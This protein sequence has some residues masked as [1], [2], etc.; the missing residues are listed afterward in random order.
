M[1]K[2]PGHQQHPDH[3]VAEKHLGERIRVTVANEAVAD[4]GDVI[5]VEED[6][7]PERYYFPRSDVAMERLER[8][9]TKTRCPF[10]GTARYFNLQIDGQ[11]LKDVVWSYEEPYEEHAALKGRLA[12]YDEKVPQIS[13]APRA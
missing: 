3:R 5:K 12:F 4:S 8:S 11:E 1:T 6:G 10:K 9:A 7:S 13:I 2:S